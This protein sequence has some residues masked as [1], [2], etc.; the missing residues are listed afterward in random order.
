[1]ASSRSSPPAE[2][3]PDAGGAAVRSIAAARPMSRVRSMSPGPV[4]SPRL[5][6]DAVQAALAAFAGGR[7]ARRTA[8]GRDRALRRS[9]FDGA[10]RR[11]GPRGGD[12]AGRTVGGPRPPRPVPSRRRLG[13]VLRR[14]LP[15]ARRR[16]DD[17]PRR[18]RA[19][20]RAEPGSGRARRALCGLRRPRRRRASRSRTTPT[21]RPRRCCC[22]CCAAPVRTA[23]PR[24]PAA[25]RRARRGRRCCGRCW[26][27]RARAIDAYVGA[28][29]IAHVDDDSNADVALRRN[30]LRH[31]VVPLLAA[32]FPGYPRD[33]RPRRRRTRPRRRSCSTSWP[34]ST[35]AAPIA[36]A[37]PGTAPTDGDVLDRRALTALS[38]ARARNLLRWFLRRHD[39]R[40]P[41]A[42][43][44]ASML[45]PDRRIR[46]RRAG[47][48]RARR[49]D[50]RHSP[51]VDRDP[52]R[53]GRRLGGRVARRA[54]ARAAAR[55][56]GSSRALAEGGDQAGIASRRAGGPPA[57][58]CARHAAANACGSP[59]AGPD[60]R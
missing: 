52:P 7:P 29:G 40:A 28:R 46:R 38:D 18:R 41:S 25:R 48:D 42:A 33:A 21:T 56:A 39:L 23:S 60:G 44:L 4:E 54:R 57:G 53:A 31:E 20:R 3:P 22:S 24:W 55:H 32:A 1:M 17:P 36:P 43:R 27:C 2:R 16:A 8:A 58:R 51:R 12:A 10:A 49:R 59:P 34:R 37:L 5:V 9:R 13:G 15:R 47:G 45:Q 14:R 26:R 6:E 19:P 35:R 30:R 50:A 11:R